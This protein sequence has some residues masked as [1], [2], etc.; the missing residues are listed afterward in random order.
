L[1]QVKSLNPFDQT[2]SQDSRNIS[3]I[4]I[5]VIDAN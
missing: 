2:V 5:G 4:N 1:N 3:H